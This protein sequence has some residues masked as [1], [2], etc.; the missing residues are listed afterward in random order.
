MFFSL[1]MVMNKKSN[2]LTNLNSEQKKGAMKLAQFDSFFLKYLKVDTIT[3]I[4]G[5]T[6]ALVWGVFIVYLKNIIPVGPML[7]NVIAYL[8]AWFAQRLVIM[9]WKETDLFKKKTE[10]ERFLKT[11]GV[12]ILEDAYSKQN[13]VHNNDL[14]PERYHLVK[15]INIF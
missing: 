2:G 7:T 9:K 1:Q 11:K 14:S 15:D 3:L 5:F 4:E 13:T 8:M 12:E 10:E 6:G